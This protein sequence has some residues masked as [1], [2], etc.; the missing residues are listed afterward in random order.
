MDMNF[1]RN[2]KLKWFSHSTIEMINQ[3]QRCFWL[4]VNKNIK[5]PEGIQSRLANRFDRVIK[6]YFDNYRLKNMIPPV[7]KDKIRG[8]L[9][10]PF[11]ET[12]SHPI[13]NKY[14]FKGILDECIVDNNFYV[15]VDFK[16]TSS[17]PALFDSPNLE[18]KKVELMNV[19][20]NQIEEYIFLMEKNN[21]PTGKYGYLIFFYPDFSN[22]VH[23]GFPMRVDIKK[24]ENTKPENALKRINKAIEILEGPLPS[25]SPDCNFC[26]WFKDVKEYYE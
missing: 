26:S 22:E 8:K 24:I 18:P 15:P 14:G 19:Y 5:Q 1:Q 20:K 7:I 13:N 11:K 21:L 23:N 2:N 25:P 16:T 3:C 10:N 17:D 4:R 6:N 9:Q 12:Y